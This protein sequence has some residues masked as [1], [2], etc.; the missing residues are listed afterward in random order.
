MKGEEAIAGDDA[1]AHEPGLSQARGARVTV[2][3]IKTGRDEPCP[4]I[5]P[6]LFVT[7]RKVE[8]GGALS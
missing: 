7:L 2:G 6:V 4:Y 8:F 5:D 1:I 3:K